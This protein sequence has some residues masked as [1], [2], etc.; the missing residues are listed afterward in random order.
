VATSKCRNGNGLG[1]A[2]QGSC[3]GW[4]PAGFPPPWVKA[5]RDTA[6]DIDTLIFSAILSA[7][8]Q[9]AAPSLEVTMSGIA[10]RTALGALAAKDKKSREERERAQESLARKV[11]ELARSNADLEQFVYVASH[12][13]QEPLRMVAAYTQLL[14]ERYRGRLDDQADQYIRYVVEG[15]ARMQSLIQDLLAFSRVGRQ[16]TAVAS[17]ECNEIV[18]QAVER[19]RTTIMESGAEVTHEPLPRLLANASQLQ[20][21]FENLIGNA[22]KFRGAHPPVVKITAKKQGPEWIFSVAD[23][24]IGISAEHAQSVFIIFNRLHTRTEY[25]GNGIGL[26]IC[27]KIVERHGG[28]IQAMPHEG[29]GT[30]FKFTMPAETLAEIQ[31]SE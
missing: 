7:G 3:P 22:I 29:E 23:N 25:S 14:A 1:L 5:S 30:I 28:E 6:D 19:L 26:A 20:Q 11:E 27:K 12:D 8:G 15:A 9:R 21:V 4:Q 31:A 13:L 18:D 2:G 16:D 17:T 24:G 10:T